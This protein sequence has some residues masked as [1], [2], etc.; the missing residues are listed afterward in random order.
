VRRKAI[1]RDLGLAIR[2][3][4]ALALIGVVYLAA[5]G[6]LLALF[7]VALGEGDV[8]AAAGAA[9]FAAGIPFLLVSHARR[10]GSLALRMARARVLEPGKEPELQ[11]LV[12]RVAAQA[13]LPGPRLAVVQSPAE[14]AFA[15]GTSPGQATVAL[16]TGIVERLDKEELE[17]VVA[18]EI[19]HI[20]N[21]DTA[22]MTFV[23]GPALAGWGMRHSDD[24]RLRLTFPLYLPIHLLGLLLMWSIFALPR[25]RRRPRLGAHHGRSRAVDERAPEARGKGA[26][27]R[28]T[29]RSC[30]QRALHR[31]R[32]SSAPPRAP[33]GPS[34]GREAT[35]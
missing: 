26:R 17:A 19:S 33:H 2:M 13:D 29:R 5:E 6:A 10:A 21:R 1:G 24:F 22:V 35:A 28:P 12:A 34:A 30:D 23:S 14:N 25:V 15:V 20:A 9:M 32:A 16:T 18:H 11:A 4:V 27:G 7:V 31:L 3:A 8:A